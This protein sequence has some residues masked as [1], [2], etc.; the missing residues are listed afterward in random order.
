MMPPRCLILQQMATIGSGHS[1]RHDPTL[2]A[3]TNLLS[4]T[5]QVATCLGSKR[6]WNRLAFATFSCGH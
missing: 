1:V 3:G 4:A 5:G 6:S 2:T